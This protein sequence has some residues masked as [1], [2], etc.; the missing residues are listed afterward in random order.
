[1]NTIVNEK[2]PSR[3]WQIDFMKIIS[4]IFVVSIHVFMSFRMNRG[5]LFVESF[6]R[7]CVPVFFICN[8]YFMFGTDK[9]IL[10]IYKRLFS[11]II[12]PT[13]LTLAFI[14]FFEHFIL[15]ELTIIQC[16]KQITPLQIGEFLKTVFLWKI[17]GTG[18][19]LWYITELI[20]L[21]ICYPLLKLV[22]VDEKRINNIRRYC[23]LIVFIVEIT[24]PTFNE[25][26]H[27][28]DGV[29]WYSPLSDYWYFYVLL[30]YEFKLYFE[31]Y[32]ANFQSLATGGSLYILGSIITYLLTKYFDVG[33]N[34]QFDHLF[35]NY[36]TINV[37]LSSIGFFLLVYSLGMKWDSLKQLIS[38]FAER[39]YVLYLIHYPIIL[40]AI[41]YGI[42]DL[43]INRLPLV[44][45]YPVFIGL[46]YAFSM[47]ASVILN[48]LW[49]TIKDCM[50]RFRL[51]LRLS[52]KNV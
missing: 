43:L 50:V 2:K 28:S 8:G 51:L 11:S 36:E 39:T 37:A 4:S 25:I 13:V 18:F 49:R 5:V 21:Y 24:V 10:K 42:R 44:L 30:G 6:T 33:Y 46:C 29:R 16:V 3:I 27:I 9:N 34:N 7:C 52:I 12:I 48:L 26:F 32:K 22:C 40:I 45:F 19:Y 1:M 31:K 23:M 17:P 20:H 35:F 41:N 14:E 15:G 47:G 38:Y